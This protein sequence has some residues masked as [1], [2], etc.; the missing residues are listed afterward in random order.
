MPERTPNLHG[1]NTCFHKEVRNQPERGG[2]AIANAPP[3][4]LLSWVGRHFRGTRDHL[5]ERPDCSGGY[6]TGCHGAR[7][8]TRGVGARRGVRYFTGRWYAAR[9][10]SAGITTSAVSTGRPEAK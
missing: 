8:G 2:R 7:N 3:P 5:G 4:V 1:A 6:G 10:R 9:Y